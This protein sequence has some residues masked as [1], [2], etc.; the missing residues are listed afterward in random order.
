MSETLRRIAVIGGSRIPF[1]R[2]NSMY[3][4]KTNLDML[5]AALQGLSDRFGLDD[6]Q[7]LLARR[8]RSRRV[9]VLGGGVLGIE[10]IAAAQGLDLERLQKKNLAPATFGDIREFE[11]YRDWTTTRLVETVYERIATLKKLARG[12]PDVDLQARLRNLFKLKML[13]LR[14]SLC[15]GRLKRWIKRAGWPRSHTGQF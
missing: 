13:L 10:L 15:R 9:V 6:A 8:V 5:A 12:H 1:C 4:S 11:R 7:R 14:R 2:S 3:A